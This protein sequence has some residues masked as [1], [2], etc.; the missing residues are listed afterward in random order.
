LKQAKID[1]MKIGI[2]GSRGIPNA[3]GGFEQFAGHLSLGLAKKGHDVFVYNSTLHPYKEKHWQNVNIIY[4]KDWEDKLEAAGQFIYDL[5]CIR[6]ARKRN[7]DILLQ[8]GYTSNSIW[9]WRW[10]KNSINIINMDG[11]EWKRTQYSTLT[12]MFIKQAEAWAAKY[13]DLLIADSPAIQEYLQNNYN[14]ASTYISYGAEIFNDP[15]PTFL[16]RFNLQPHQYY[17]VVARMEPENN[18]EMIIAGYLQT[19]QNRPLVIVG[20]ATNQLGKQL[21]RKYENEKIRFHGSIYDQVILDN[22]RFFSRI[23]FHGHSVGGTNPSLLE[24]MACS[25]SIVAHDNIFNQAVLSDNAMYFST[26]E[27]VK[28]IINHYTPTDKGKR[29]KNIEKI[30]TEY[31]WNK[32]IEKYEILFLNAMSLKKDEKLFKLA[33]H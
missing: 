8:L 33:S 20:N 2:L 13:G 12:R 5:N 29:E 14:R 11:L 32:I 18:I 3:Y 19:E 24:A 6:D 31:N 26:A 7:F 23:Y 10:P 15:N 27:E 25:C 30:R 17:L 9:H 1:Q 22:L 16:R 21:T 28:N 4:C